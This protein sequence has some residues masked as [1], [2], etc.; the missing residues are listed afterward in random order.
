MI[1]IRYNR[2]S[3]RLALLYLVGAGLFFDGCSSSDGAPEISIEESHASVSVKGF[4]ES[5]LLGKEA[6]DVLSVYVVED[7]K[8]WEPLDYSIQG[9]YH[10]EDQTLTFTPRYS[11]LENTEYYVRFE[12]DSVLLEDRFIIKSDTTPATFVE[13]VY[14]TTDQI[15]RN[16]LKFY[17]QFSGSMIE[18]NML[19]YVYVVDSDG[20]RME[21]VFLEIP[22]ELWDT[23]NTRLTILFDPARIKRGMDAL[24]EYGAPFQVGQSYT[25]I[26]DSEFKDAGNRALTESYEKIFTIVEDDRVKPESGSW[27]VITPLVNSEQEL[28]LDFFEPMDYGLL[29]R[30]IQV[31][32]E[33]GNLVN[34]SITLEEDQTQ[35]V[36]SPEDA[37]SDE[38]Y[39]IQI[40]GILEDL[41][42]NNLITLFDVDLNSEAKEDDKEPVG[43]FVELSFRPVKN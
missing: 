40:E 30:V 14:P 7:G 11:F 6:S 2:I 32:D 27:E 24:D 34:G 37:W 38:K 15:P 28:V 36:F 8:E 25:L 20:L 19:D 17:A 42:G 33:N 31:I 41:A 35:W 13:D 4:D 9:N 18:G 26:I 3:K 21:H 29:N 12:L 22:Q 23:E 43:T 5:Q 1:S 10:F 39:T 16:V